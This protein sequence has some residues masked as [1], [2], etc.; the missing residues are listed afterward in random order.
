[1]VCNPTG[2]YFKF[3]QKIVSKDSQKAQ[4]KFRQKRKTSVST[5]EL[6]VLML[7]RENE[8]THG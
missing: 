3:G 1:M 4:L 7:C 6:S 5:C 2:L 8:R